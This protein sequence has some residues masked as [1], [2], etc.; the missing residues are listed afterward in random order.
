MLFQGSRP[1]RL[2]QFVSGLSGVLHVIR[3]MLSWVCRCLIKPVWPRWYQAEFIPAV[4]LPAGAFSLVP[5]NCSVFSGMVYVDSVEQLSS[6]LVPMA[7]C[8]FVLTRLLFAPQWFVA[9]LGSAALFIGSST[10]SRHPFR[11]IKCLQQMPHWWASACCRL[12]ST[13]APPFP[14]QPIKQTDPHLQLK[15]DTQSAKP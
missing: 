9:V 12:P 5:P 1:I 4:Q 2:L 7:T 8:I 14:L 6:C 10:C 15:E 3:L 11:W 13:S